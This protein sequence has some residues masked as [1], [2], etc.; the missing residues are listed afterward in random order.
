MVRNRDN[1]DVPSPLLTLDQLNEMLF[2][3]IAHAGAIGGGMGGGAPGASGG[4]KGGRFGARHFT[5]LDGEQQVFP[6]PRSD[7]SQQAVR[8]DFFGD[9]VLEETE[10]PSASQDAT[11]KILGV[12]GSA[13]MNMNPCIV[14]IVWSPSELHAFAHA[15]EGV[16][17]Q[18]TCTKALQRLGEVV[19]AAGQR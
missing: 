8:I 1:S 10:E 14:Q 15:R 19:D 16:F 6:I 18:R 3:G 5:R 4:A 7:A 13:T 17:K 11:L 9:G 12:V 2:D